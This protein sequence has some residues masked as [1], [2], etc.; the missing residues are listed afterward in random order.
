MCRTFG[1]SPA[2]RMGICDPDVA[3]DVD[4]YA[5]ELLKAKDPDP[6]EMLAA[7]LLNNSLSG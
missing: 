5:S 6:T 7:A 3:D 4:I 1:Q 2:A